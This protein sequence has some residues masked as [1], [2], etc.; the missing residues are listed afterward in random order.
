MPLPIHLALV[1]VA[2][3]KF[4]D[5]AKVSAAIQKQIIRDFTPIWSVEATIDAFPTPND[6][7]VGYFPIYIVDTFD[8]GGQH[9]S[10]NNQPFAL[11][12]AG[13]S[14]SLA[15]SHEALEMLVDPD[16][17]RLVAGTSPIDSQGR[18]EFLVEVCDPCQS[19]REAYTVNGVLVSDFCTPEYY[20]P[21]GVMGARYSYS[22]KVTAPH[23]VLPG[24]YLSW[25]DPET[26]D[27]FQHNRMKAEV[28]KNLGP[29][30]PAAMMSLRSMIDDHSAPPLPLSNL[31]ANSPAL[32]RA[33]RVRAAADRAAIEQAKPMKE[34]LRRLRRKPARPRR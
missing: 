34:F 21:V 22:G 1:P 10:V 16:G 27:W 7:P 32:R 33:Q 6:V 25:H 9:K 3:V 23:Q 13:K 20:D 29:I 11:V 18:V 2:S 5:V 14:W 12:A 19:E 24:G 4:N 26:G 30:Q 8:S 31:K 15:A 28:I 17:N